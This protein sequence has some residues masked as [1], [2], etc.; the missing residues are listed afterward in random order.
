ME[1]FPLIASGFLVGGAFGYGVAW[2]AAKQISLK[3]R[4]LVVLVT[5]AIAFFLGL[6]L[7]WRLIILSIDL[8]N[9][10]SDADGPLVFVATGFVTL[11]IWLPSVCG[12]MIGSNYS[13][14]RKARNR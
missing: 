6:P 8:D 4:W 12:A 2:V 11:A 3:W 10:N 7:T 14:R 1:W 5:G 13:F 9:A